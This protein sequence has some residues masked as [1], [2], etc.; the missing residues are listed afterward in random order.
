LQVAF[1]LLKQHKT[2][3][4]KPF[5]GGTFA[6]PGGKTY[7]IAAR[8][9]NG[10]GTIV[11]SDP[12]EIDGLRRVEALKEVPVPKRKRAAAKKSS[13]STVK[14]TSDSGRQPAADTTTIT[15]RQGAGNGNAPGE[16]SGNG[17]DA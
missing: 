4:P 10:N 14:Q 13:G 5:A 9:R 11:T 12:H 7:D 1:E 17:G 2:D 15:P 6:L 16:G 3:G 8:L